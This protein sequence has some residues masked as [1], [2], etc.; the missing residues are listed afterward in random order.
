MK[1]AVKTSRIVEAFRFGKVNKIGLYNSAK[2]IAAIAQKNAPYETGK[3][4]QSIGMHPQTISE[5][6][7][8]VRVGSRKVIYSLRREYENRKN[9]DRKFYMKKTFQVS[10]PIVKEE[11]TKATRIVLS[12]LGKR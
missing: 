8:V 10:S 12:S 7:G 4:K 6:T 11:F 2:R 1:I 3:L 5:G 9:P